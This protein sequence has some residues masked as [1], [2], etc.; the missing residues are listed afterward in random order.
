[1]ATTPAVVVVATATFVAGKEVAVVCVEDTQWE[2]V[3]VSLTVVGVKGVSSRA[4]ATPVGRVAA[5]GTANA[6][7]VATLVGVMAT[8]ASAVIAGVTVV[9]GSPSALQWER[10]T[11][12]L[13]A[14]ANL[15]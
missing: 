2:V 15:D 4:K 8:A 1:M 5:T 14:R 13:M 7:V 10:T 9:R 3:A 11:M 6:G 12:E